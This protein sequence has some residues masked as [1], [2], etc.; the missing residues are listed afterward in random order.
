MLKKYLDKIWLWQPYCEALKSVRAGLLWAILITATL[1]DLIFGLLFYS[2]WTMP[3]IIL[4]TLLFIVAYTRIEE[5]YLEHA[6]RFDRERYASRNSVVRDRLGQSDY[7]LA[8]V[9]FFHR[10]AYALMFLVLLMSFL[11]RWGP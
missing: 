1:S 8:K 3:A 10:F 9:V 7:K 5:K 4:I 11:T 6:W 2:F